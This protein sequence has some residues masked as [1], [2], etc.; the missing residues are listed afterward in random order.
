MDRAMEPAVL[1]S[2]L[3]E[4]ETK[5]LW[6]FGYGSLCYKPG[7]EFNK[8]ILGFV[9]GFQRRFWQGN[10]THR[11]T[12][13]QPGRVATLIEDSDGVVHGVAY[14]ISGEAAIPYLNHREC[15]QGG[16]I[17]KIVDFHSEKGECFKVMIYVACPA[18]EHWLGDSEIDD[19]AGEIISSKG[20]SGHNVE[21]L[22]RLAEFMRLHFPGKHDAHLFS[23]E[24]RVLALVKENQMCLDT[25][26]GSGEGC[27][28]FIRR[29]NSRETSPTQDRRNGRQDTFEGTTEGSS[30][31]LRCLNI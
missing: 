2:K 26:M 12:K 25:L 3:S 19:I 28:T 10:V 15:Q 24:D 17:A 18:N 5:F 16:Y 7:F 14:A 21:Y 13:E 8:A 23:L 30:S 29:A 11:G 1:E 31:R 20:P 6:V 27:I 9:N 4:S 22:I